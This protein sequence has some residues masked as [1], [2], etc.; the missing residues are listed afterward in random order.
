M[1][2]LSSDNQRRDQQGEPR[3]RVVRRGDFTRT[4]EGYEKRGCEQG[5]RHDHARDNSAFP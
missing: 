4:L 1:T 3:R 5:Q 2:G